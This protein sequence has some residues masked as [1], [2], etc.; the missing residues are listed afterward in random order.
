MS[1]KAKYGAICVGFAVM[2]FLAGCSPE[3][4]GHPAG[5]QI[6]KENPLTS[7]SQ[8]IT[9]PIHEFQV[10][11]GGTYPLDINVKN[12]G[13]QPWVG[14][15]QATTVAA[16]Y[17]WLDNKGNVLPIEGN[18][19]QLDRSVVQPG[20]SDSLK[21]QVGAPPKAGSYTLWVS[22]VQEGV[23]WFYDRGAKPLVLH[24]NVD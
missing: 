6:H 10:K 16:G 3:Q 8:E 14:G 15:G 4:E 1:N 2:I 21:L 7:F 22:M 13:T 17:R 24:V 9:S 11:T 19:A 12:T 23:A 5:Q 18:R 20:E